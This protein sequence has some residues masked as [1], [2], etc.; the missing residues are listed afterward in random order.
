MIPYGLELHGTVG[1]AARSMAL[2]TL[3]V[4]VPNSFGLVLCGTFDRTDHQSAHPPDLE[5]PQTKEID[6]I[7]F[8]FTLKEGRA[9]YGAG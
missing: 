7:Y 4:R 8:I 3:Q 2:G 6:Q 5:M 1:D 9:R